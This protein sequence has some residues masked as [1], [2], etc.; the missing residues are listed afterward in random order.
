MDEVLHSQGVIMEDLASVRRPASK[1]KSDSGAMGWGGVGGGI[2]YAT[3]P[4]FT[5]RPRLEAGVLDP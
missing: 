3:L 2:K 4:S 5:L 1:N